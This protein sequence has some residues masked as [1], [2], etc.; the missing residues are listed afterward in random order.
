MNKGFTLIETLLSLFITMIC[1][2]LISS[3]IQLMN[4]MELTNESA[5]DDLSLY[6]LRLILALSTDVE[7]EYHCVDFNYQNDM[8]TLSLNDDTLILQP[9]YQVFLQNVDGLFFEQSKDDLYITYERDGVH[10]KRFLYS[11]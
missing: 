8:F 3:C 1:L 11:E 10:V 5:K 2:L 9:G 4:R 6:N 7:V